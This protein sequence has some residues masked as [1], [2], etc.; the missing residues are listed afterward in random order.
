LEILDSDMTTQSR[1]FRVALSFPGE[2]RAF[3]SQVAEY[4][5]QRLGRERVFYDAY[6][7]AE[8]ARPDLDLYLGNIYRNDSDLVVP[9]FCA[10]YDRKNWCRLEWRQMRDILLNL[11]GHR[12]MPF[13]FDDTPIPG[14][15]SIDGYLKI[16]KRSPQE[17][18]ELILQR[19]SGS[20]VAA[21]AGQG[22]RVDFLLTNIREPPRATNPGTLLNARYEVVPFFE[23]ART[24]ELGDLKTWCEDDKLATSVR[25]FYGPGG[26]GKTRLFIEWAKQLRKQ[27]W[28][29]GFLA[30]QVKDDQ[31][32]SILHTDRPMLVVLDYAECRIGLHEFLKRMAERPAEQAQ[33]L[34]IALLAR[35]V[36]D[37]WQSLLQRDEAVRHLLVQ[38][39]PTFIAP[40]ALEGP[41][42]RRIWEHARD[43]FAERLQKPAPLGVVDFEDECLGRIL[44]L[45][46]SALATVE[47]M[48]TKAE[49]LVDEIAAHERR[50]WTRRYREQFGKDDFEAVDFDKRCSRFVAALT[51]QG[52]APSREAAEA[53]N[54]RVEGPS[55]RYE[56]LIAFL[57]SLY[58][59]R[60]QATQNRYLGGLEPDLLG[61][62]LVWSVL[63]DPE[64][65]P[66]TFLE[67]VFT[68]AGEAALGNG[69]VILGRIS[70]QDPAVAEPWLTGMLKADVPGRSRP[71]FYAALALGTQT[72]FS[73][74]GLILAQVLER[75]GTLDLAVGF[76]QLLPDQTVSLREVAVWTGRRMLQFLS[77]QKDTQ[78]NLRERARIL[79]NLAPRLRAL[80]RRD[81]ALQTAQ[82]AVDIRRR[83]AEISPD[84]QLPDLA[85]SLSNLGGILCDCGRSQEAIQALQEAF[86]IHDH[87][88]RTKPS[89]FLPYVAGDLNNLCLALSD[90]GRQ[91]EAL[92]AAQNAVNISRRIAE[93]CRDDYLQD[94]AM[95]LNN[96]GT[97]LSKLERREEA[98]QATRESLGIYR[99]LAKIHPDVFL[100]DLA[101]NLNNLGNRL[102]G[103]GQW[104]DALEAAKEAIG[105]YRR[106][107]GDRPDAF[108]PD[109][110]GSL[111]NL[112][113]TLGIL[114]LQEDALRAAREAVDIRRRLAK[115]HPDTLLPDLAAS[116]NTL[117]NVLSSLGRS[118]EAL[119]TVQEAV[120]IHRRFARDLPNAFL[121][122]LAISLHNLGSTLRDLHRLEAGLQATQEALEIQRRLN[123]DH[124]NTFLPDVAASLHNLGTMLGQVGR[125]GDALPV[126]QEA[127]DIR[128]SLTMT[129]TD[130]FLPDLGMS[131]N[132]LSIVL[133]ALGRRE[134][135]LQAAQ[136]ACD[137]Y[138]RL[139]Q[140]RP[141]AFLPELARSLVTVGT[142]LAAAARL[143]EAV[144][145][146]AEGVH[147]LAGK[148]Y[149]LPRAFAPL[150]RTLVSLYLTHVKELGESPDMELLAPILAKLE[151]I[152]R[153]EGES[154]E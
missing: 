65:Q 40:V 35:D 31:V 5:S 24:R 50:F 1:R 129:L 66:Q 62:T 96:L 150:M 74:L 77:T 36:A 109:L 56:H 81:E 138:G 33:R 78:Q 151:E 99:R 139:A 48:G 7:E 19:L 55:L 63:T 14:F 114:G 8:L 119:R 113:N 64:N 89:V 47:G 107:A 44:Y 69:F 57:R 22:I 4:L 67:Q 148:F 30:E 45:H 135:A 106:L 128:R 80:G 105:T 12:I 59:G 79:N 101:L 13:R 146:F 42:R 90:V 37:W 28:R 124:P 15:L 93:H 103:L 94:L 145:I 54:R 70:L 126:A 132:S 60:G 118:D 27:G 9:F 95:G 110:A 120:S 6:Y 23:E 32:E 117:S 104:E 11:E 53:L 18:A 143:H 25:L 2:K 85:M 43:A 71:A 147:T 26:T 88:A 84:T 51:L 140:V 41:L 83:L 153:S 38:A 125:W 121:P 29:A 136:E 76:D 98:S 134:Q 144:G 82:E 115:V 92:E 72:A 152:K 58:P 39:E 111:T 68:G 122:S 112:A 97:V 10:P 20:P 127:V 116:L 141:D 149:E 17:V 133:G 16:E 46:M 75:E 137:V 86:A 123:E 87:L 61:E 142:C 108:E 130:T 73:P 49:A 3:V 34:R 131:L 154:K 102:A 91:E 21:P 52:G 100:P